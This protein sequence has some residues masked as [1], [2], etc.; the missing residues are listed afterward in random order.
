MASVP[1]GQNKG[2]VV[3]VLVGQSEVVWPLDLLVRVKKVWPLCLSPSE[4][5]MASGPVN[6]SKRD[7]VGT[8]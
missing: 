1:V 8:I 5:G 2:S 4:G 7:I 6:P 3:S